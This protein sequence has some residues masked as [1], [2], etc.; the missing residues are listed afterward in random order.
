MQYHTCDWASLVEVA[1]GAHRTKRGPSAIINKR[2]GP[3]R[4]S[5]HTCVWQPGS[6]IYDL[7][8]SY[9]D[10]RTL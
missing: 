9:V 3:V 4:S 7:S 2:R 8:A 5:S 6:A 1:N 10:P